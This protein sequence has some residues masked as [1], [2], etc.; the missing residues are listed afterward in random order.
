[1][2]TQK[3]FTK[4]PK[5]WEV[6]NKEIILLNNKL[7][8]DLPF[9]LNSFNDYPISKKT[10]HALKQNNYVVPTDIQ[11]ESIL[12]ALKGHDI[13]GAAKTGSGKTLAF[14]IPVLENL[15][16]ANW[17]SMDGLGALIISPTRELAYQTFE[18]LKR[19]GC[20]HEFSA[21]IVIG[22][23]DLNF[24]KQKIFQTNILVCTPGRLLQHLE[25]TSFFVCDNLKILVLDEA[26][27]ILDLGFQETINA[28]IESIPQ[29]RQTLLFSATQT[30]NVKD[31]A[32]L[33]LKDPIYVS[34]HENSSESTPPQLFQTY[35]VCELH[36]KIS[37]LY[38]FIKT[39]LKQKILV[40]LTSCKQVKYIYTLF[41]RLKP[42]ISVLALYGTMNQMK[43]VSSYE[44]FSNKASALLI[45]TDIAARGLDFPE[46]HWVVQMDCP[47]DANTYI[48]RVGRTARYYK[49]GKSLIFLMPNEEKMFLSHLSDKKIP[50][51]KTNINP[52]RVLSI[53]GKAESAC[54]KD[55]NLKMQ[56]QKCFLS[57]IR[58]MF[59]MKDKKL[60]DIS[61][62][63]TDKYAHSLGMAIPPRIRF[64]Q[65]NKKNNPNPA[66][67][68]LFI[69]EAP[70]IDDV[71]NNHRRGQKYGPSNNAVQ[72]DHLV[73]NNENISII[74]NKLAKGLSAE[75]EEEEEDEGQFF[76]LKKETDT[77]TWANLG[78]KNLEKEK[79]FPTKK[80]IN[81]PR[82][83][84]FAEAKKLARLALKKNLIVNKRI[85][86]DD[87]GN[88]IV[89]STVF[90]I[91][92]SLGNGSIENTGLDIEKAKIRLREQDK[93]DK[94][95]YREKIK[96]QHKDKKRKEKEAKKLRSQPTNHT[97][98]DESE[99]DYEEVLE[100]D[101]QL[102]EIV[103][104]L[105]DPDIIYGNKQSNARVEDTRD[106][107]RDGRRNKKR[108]RL[109]VKNKANSKNISSTKFSK[110]EDTLKE[111]EGFACK[112]MEHL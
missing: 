65:K 43:R 61:K 48:H 64:L 60:F 93:I 96:A 17:T 112:L 44:Q 28:I 15:Y 32:R 82:L 56:A 97:Q 50:I 24:E 42:G 31:L 85:T 27:R 77:G 22:G 70:F 69:G 80:M 25:Q 39:H 55:I 49:D 2:K 13:L 16:R 99:A 57:Y 66:K 100:D 35:L 104:A 78:K 72:V 36:E 45:A 95:A 63:D 84:R 81:K 94:Q 109:I 19:I 79:S 29:E 71:A 8:S 40:F 86:Y 30:K 12:L 59:L 89:N 5:K 110:F 107:H 51:K 68:S 54:A 20:K 88:E 4:K 14:L 90:K 108:K 6:E 11:K 105:P 23:K 83:S 102:A 26:D 67:S 92:E 33:S 75:Q 37:L 91:Q 58:A 47:E 106:L 9:L 10:F 111:V 76:T 73:Y 3:I 53:Q 34:A 18:I 21:G 52:E 41:C 98:D 87:D 103:H 1:M 38:S 7:N 74:T 101:P 62:L 46:V